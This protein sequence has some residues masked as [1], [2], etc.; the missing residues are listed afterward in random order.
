MHAFS[1]TNGSLHC[2]EVDLTSIAQREG[3]P[4][5]VYSKRTIL[6]HF[7]RLREELS[8]VH[9]EVSFAVKSCSNLAILSLMARHGA[10]FDIVSGGELFRVIQAG[11]DPHHCTY[12]GVGKTAEEIRY[13]LEQEIYCFNVESVAELQLINDLAGQ[14]GGGV[15]APVA[16]RVNPNVEAGT[17][18]YITTGKSENKFGID[19]EKVEAL[20]AHAADTMPHLHLKGV[21]MH[22]GSQLTSVK[23][24]VEAV[25]RVAPLVKKLKARFGIEFFSLG[26]G[27]G[28]VYE[29]SLKSGLPT[30]WESSS[31][32]LTLRSYAQALIPMLK[33]LDVHI[34]VEPGRMIVGN[35]GVLLAQCLYEKVGDAKTFKIID[36]GMNDLIRPALY[37]GHH[38]IMPL[39]E[40]A[41]TDTIIAD[42]VGPICESGDFFAQNREIANIQQGE[43]IAVMSTGAYGFSMSSNYN[44]R[45]MAAEVLVDGDHWSIIR[46]RQTREDLIAGERIPSDL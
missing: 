11:G 36:A 34:I 12:A 39:R 19:F 3:T 29:N 40:H 44:S 5:Y 8:P 26:G 6:E 1:Y 25:E 32:Q 43:L 31:E 33:P 9:A 16:I 15:K 46:Q 38:E 45:P 24:F 30:W 17:H 37:Q 41:M 10:G 22:I 7:S 2:E 14:M 20:Y 28:I 13:A 4:V 23:P 27:I 35:A 18:K 21:Q 42:V